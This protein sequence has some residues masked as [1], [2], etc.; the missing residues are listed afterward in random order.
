PMAIT[1]NS[2]AAATAESNN[3]LVM[4]FLHSTIGDMH[5]TERFRSLLRVEAT[6]AAGDQISRLPI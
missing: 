6:G 3:G 5:P 4:A 1:A 2:D